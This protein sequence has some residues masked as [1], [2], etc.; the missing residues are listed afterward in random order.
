VLMQRYGALSAA[1]LLFAGMLGLASTGH[2]ALGWVLI[3]LALAALGFRDI[4]QTR[5]SILRNYPI[6]GHLRFFFEA[7]RPELRQYFFDSDLDAQPFSRAQRSVAYQRA[8]N[9]IDARPFGTELDVQA[10]GHEWLTHSMSPTTI[11][12]HDFRVVIGEGRAQPYSMSLLNIS[13]MSF[14]AL[15]ANAIRALNLGAKRGNFAH[16]TGE[17]SLSKYHR[18]NGGDIVYQI[19]SGYFGCRTED[20]HFSPDEFCLRALDPQVKMIEVK[21]SQGAKPGHG[22]VLPAAKVTEEIADTRGVPRGEACVSPSAHSEFSTPKELL[23]FIEKLRNLSRGKPTGIKLCVGHPWELFAI[24]HAIVET[25]ILP[26]FFVVDGAEGGTGAAPLEFADHVGSPLQEG[27]LL[28][29]NMLVGI[30]VRD[31]VKIG[32]SGKIITGFDIAR[33]LA[34]GADFCNSA[35]GMLFAVGCIQAQS[36]NSGRCPTGVATQ[37]KGRQRALVVPDKAE[38]VYHFHKNTLHAFQELLEAAGLHSPAQLRP[39][40]LVRRI[41]S[42]EV[43]RMSD[44]LDYLEPGDLLEGNYRYALYEKWWPLARSDSFALPEEAISDCRLMAPKKVIWAKVEPLAA[45]SH[46]SH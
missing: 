34:L 26:D 15:S 12:G 8:K 45:A 7:I 22:G 40:H 14:G 5:H 17:G 23:H 37:D 6:I 1:I 41:S 3:P 33:T 44:L 2:V 39:H 10:T 29:H 11:D 27:L 42:Y 13:A 43:R 18:E 9:T 36:C 32:A 28:V 25:G 16:D 20:G 4:L 19:A 30:G 24:G 38:R 21:L 31:K 46:T 35:R